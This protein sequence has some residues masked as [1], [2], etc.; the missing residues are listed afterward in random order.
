M[1]PRSIN[2]PLANNMLA[3]TEKW[4]KPQH[5]IQ[6]YPKAYKLWS[7]VLKEL[8]A[9]ITNTLSVCRKS[10]GDTAPIQ[11][12]YFT[13]QSEEKKTDYTATVGILR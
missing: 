11:H 9:K 3:N 7:L 8:K 13:K 4:T 5:Y 12:L 6:L 2:V 1:S 10:M